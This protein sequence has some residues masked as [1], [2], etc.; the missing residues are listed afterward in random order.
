MLLSHTVLSELHQEMLVTE[1]E[2]ERMK[3]EGGDLC[4]KLIPTQCTKPPE[5]VA[6][7]TDVLDKLGYSNEASHLQG[8]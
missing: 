3:G 8:W 1:D 6:K 2:L 4:D 7:T 5:V